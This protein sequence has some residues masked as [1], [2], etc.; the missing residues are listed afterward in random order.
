[1]GMERHIIGEETAMWTIVFLLNSAT[2][3]FLF[4]LLRRPMGEAAA[5]IVRSGCLTVAILAILSG[6]AL[7]VDI[8]WTDAGWP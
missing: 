6:C 1:M 7:L 4:S 2:G 5:E 8:A 3:L